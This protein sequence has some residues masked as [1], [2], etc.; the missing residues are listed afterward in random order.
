MKPFGWLRTG[1][2]EYGK[3]HVESLILDV[4]ILASGIPA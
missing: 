1:F 2:A 3:Y 4:G